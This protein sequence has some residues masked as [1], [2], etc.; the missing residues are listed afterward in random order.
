[1]E[2]TYPVVNRAS[3]M[4]TNIPCF[5]DDTIETI[6]F[7]IGEATNIHPDRMRIYIKVELDKDYYTKDS[8]KWESLYIR[9]SPEGK[10]V[11]PK[12]LT[13][14]NLSRDPSYDFPQP[15]YDKTGW[16]ALD[17]GS[18]TSF[19][20]LR[21]FG[22]PE[23]RS[24]VF[25]LTNEPAE[26][27]PVPSKAT[28]EV[29]GLLK[30]LHPQ[31]IIG[32]EVIPYSEGISPQTE[33]VYFP[34]LRRGSPLVPQKDIIQYIHRQSELLRALF[35]ISVP[36]PDKLTIV[37]GR[38]KLPLVNTDFGGAIRNRFE[39]IFYGTTLT[40]DIPVITFFGGRQEQSRHKFYTETTNKTP[41]L[42]VKTWNYWWT[43]TKPSKN[44]PSLLLYRGTSRNTYDR[45]TINEIEITLSSSRPADS[46][47]NVD[48]LRKS[49]KDFLLSIDGISSYLDPADVEDDRW[50]L[51]DASVILHYSRELKE[52]DF[53]RFDC[54]RNIYDI[55]DADK[56]TFRFLRSDQSDTGLTD[57]E[58]RVIQLLKENEYTNASDIQEQLPYKSMSECE[59]LLSATRQKLEDNSDLVDR[60]YALI[61]TF[62]MTAKQV[63]I[64]HAKD[65]R[66][67][68]KYIS[69]LRDIL[70]NPENPELDAVCPKRV[71]SVSPETA[72]IPVTAQAQDAIENEEDDYLNELLGEISEMT[73][74]VPAAAPVDNV[75]KSRKIKAKGVTSLATY[76][77]DQ[78]HE[79]D[80]VTFDPD[81]PQILRKCDRPRQPIV[82][83]SE[84]LSRF[85]DDLAIYKPSEQALDVKDPSGLILCPQY[86]CTI[87]R[88]PLT[89]EQLMD[90]TCPICRGKIRSNDKA[91]EKT[92]STTEFPVLERDP[93]IVYPGYV[94][95]KSKKNDRPIPCCFTTPQKTRITL[96]APEFATSAS[97]MFYILGENKT[98]L[99][100]LRVAYLQSIVIKVLF[101]DTNYKKIIDASNR[102]QTGQGDLFRAGVGHARQSLPRILE[103][104]VDVKSPIHNPDI[105]LRCSFF[106]TW[107]GADVDY[108]IPGYSS[109]ISKR[110]ASID[111]AYQEKQLTALEELEYVSLLLNCLCYMLHVNVDGVQSSCFMSF[112]AVKNMKRAIL[113]LIDSTGSP[114]YFVHVSKTTAT[115]TLRGNLYSPLFSQDILKDLGGFRQQSCTSSVPTIES[116]FRLISKTN[117]KNRYEE[118]RVILD[119]YRKA[120]G[121]F[122]PNIIILP[123]RPTSNIPTIF[124]K[125]TTYAEIPQSEYPMKTLMIEYLNIGK[126]IHSG[127]EYS[128]DVGNLK[129]NVT[130]IVTR[131]GLRIP[132]Q[133]GD[134]TQRFEEITETV[135]EKSEEKLVFGKP[136]SESV[137][138]ARSITY[139][140]EIFEFLIFEL[141]KDLVG[142]DYP[143][144]KTILSQEHP[145]IEELRV[146]LRE[147]MNTAIQFAE[148]EDPPT[149]YNKMRQSCSTSSREKCTGL[150]V[151]DGASCKVQVKQLRSGLQKETLEKRMLSTLT[152]NDKIRTIIFENRMSPFFS[153]VL[154][155]QMPHEIILSDQDVS[156]SIK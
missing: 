105:V 118:L 70:L 34:R 30:T 53:R 26:Y 42:D 120:Q 125:R 22:V 111:K 150:C 15:E 17:P 37:Q 82:M 74:S 84:E 64:T 94:K 123:F 77:M 128:H 114:D 68:V 46:N 35:E 121:F 31:K 78:L 156:E 55:T 57:E 132:V 5:V 135:F 119:P 63:A 47:E 139:E 133:T 141:S 134:T 126:D 143:T 138:L 11:T 108:E 71:E 73:P 66:R 23:E 107:K 56:L 50:E 99:E 142:N 86:W 85:T 104:S 124:E 43:A 4:T 76:F 89:K 33:L 117:L 148:A 127:Y 14:Y 19:T 72:V 130:E 28:I 109:E 3:G 145:N 62:R 153:S 95:Y 25:P 115:P 24:W 80:P 83:K 38:W 54:L 147:W 152:S 140:A 101:L 21:I 151:W 45:I 2:E 8:R 154:Y 110:I 60:Q 39:Q 51:Q 149:F 58:I 103:L 69:I 87:D 18:E 29:K 129:G 52:A 48:D 137:K 32:F 116:A 49:L 81:D 40:K 106:R 144:L 146:P 131:A 13:L 90:G 67:I 6:Q 7:R 100:E 155:L 93:S 41:F 113:V 65:I 36:S 9:M 16:M 59:L 88:I 44:R 75:K 122:I 136:D 12:C 91:V 27:L 102:L 98:G 10:I 92:Q 61:P 96:Q 20:E 97:E 112:A 1:M 79:F